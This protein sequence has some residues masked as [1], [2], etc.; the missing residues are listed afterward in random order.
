LRKRIRSN[1]ELRAGAA[2]NSAISA[3]IR[4]SIG[5][6]SIMLL[7]LFRA[8]LFAPAPLL[9]AALGALIA[10]ACGTTPSSEPLPPSPLAIEMQTGKVAEECFTLAA[11]ERIEYQFEASVALAF[12]LHTH[13]GGEIVMP[14]Q[15][16]RTREQAGIFTSPQREDYCMMWTN[17]SAV[18]ARITGQWRRLR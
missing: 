3:I 4:R 12:N 11:G 13:R 15:I 17:R 7:S 10:T 14:V 18:P 6:S 2:A 16:E 1:I 5:E 9:A 8:V